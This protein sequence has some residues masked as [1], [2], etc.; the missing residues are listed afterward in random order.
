MNFAGILETRLKENK[1][2][3]IVNKVAK[4][5][6][7]VHNYS[8]DNKGRIW[9]VWKA[10]EVDVQVLNIHAQFIHCRISDRQTDLSSLVTVIHGKNAIDERKVMWNDLTTI[11][12]NITEPWALCRDLMLYYVWKTES[13]VIPLLKLKWLT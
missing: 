4:N 10:T 1:A 6:W 9:V 3:D 7:W 5:W 11:G 8:E 13:M 12:Q 2:R